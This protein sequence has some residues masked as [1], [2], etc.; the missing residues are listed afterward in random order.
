MNV[1]RFIKGHRGRAA[2]LGVLAAGAF[3]GSASAAVSAI[4]IDPEAQLSPGRMHAMLTGTVT[5]DAG[6][7]AFLSARIVQPKSAT[8]AGQ[9]SVIC[10]GEAQPYAIDVS[11]AGGFPLPLPTSGVFKP[12]KASA[13]VSSSSCDP[14]FNC[15]TTYTD[16]IISLKR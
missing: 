11:T 2:I 8:G 13:Q 10:S 14:M 16:A 5:C 9:T 12:G 4:T 1:L 15:S 7:T 6:S 3:A